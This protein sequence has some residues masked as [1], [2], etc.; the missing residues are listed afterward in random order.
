MS[1]QPQSPFVRALLAGDGPAID[2][3][4]ASDVVFHSPVRSYTRR[5]DVLHLLSMIG[6]VLGEARVVR[7]WVGERGRAT[8]IATEQQEGSLDGIVEE[9]HAADGRIS[10]VT[11]MLRPISVMRATVGRMGAALEAAPLPSAAE[12]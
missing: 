3:V 8:V 9:R 5:D 12:H 10:E 6:G 4:L 2:R 11:L 7:S 1:V